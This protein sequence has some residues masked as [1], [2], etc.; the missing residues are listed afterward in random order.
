MIVILRAILSAI[1]ICTVL[2]F[3]FFISVADDS[4][5]IVFIGYVMR[6]CRTIP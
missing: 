1:F 4:G 3:W 6:G 2:F 5:M